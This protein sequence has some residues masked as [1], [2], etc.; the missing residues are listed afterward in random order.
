MCTKATVVLL[1][2]IYVS[3]LMYSDG[4][5]GIML[6]CILAL[7]KVSQCMND[8]TLHIFTPSWIIGTYQGQF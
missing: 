7:R 1:R 3:H 5:Y 6:G 2:L 8:S 4:D